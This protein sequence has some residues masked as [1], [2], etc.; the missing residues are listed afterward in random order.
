MTDTCGEKKA[1]VLYKSKYGNAK[2]YAGWLADELGCEAVEAGQA[3][4]GALREYD[5]VVF[6]G[7][8]YAGT[9]NGAQFVRRHHA[10][11][12][13]TVVFLVG[14]SPASFVEFLDAV[15]EKYFGGMERVTVFY[16]QGDMDYATLTPA[17]RAVM[18]GLKASVL[19]K[20]EA[21]WSRLERGVMATFGTTMRNTKQ[22][23][24]TPV[25]DYVKILLTKEK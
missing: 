20:P 13:N 8:L 11:W 19:E 15:K 7:G 16:L 21:Q 12:K 23:H 3:D 2:Q 14:A 10:E 6:G 17:H 1:I 9:V 18:D 4:E 5:V 24:I 22:E 25:A